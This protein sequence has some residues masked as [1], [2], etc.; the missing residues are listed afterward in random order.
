VCLLISL[1]LSLSLSFALALSLSLFFMCVCV[2]LRV[3]VCFNVF[4][5]STYRFIT[6]TFSVN[7]NIF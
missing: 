4:K 7:I 6:L 3:I 5:I 2:Y 1:S